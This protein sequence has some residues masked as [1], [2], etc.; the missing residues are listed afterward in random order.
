MPTAK[1]AMRRNAISV[2][3]EATV[4]EAAKL[5][6]NHD[7]DAIAVCENGKFRGLV[8]YQNIVSQ[9]VAD[10]RDAGRERVTLITS[11][12]LP[13][14]CPGIALAEAIKIMAKHRTRVVP[15]VQNGKFVGLLTMDDVMR[16]SPA[17]VVMTAQHWGMPADSRG[18]EGMAIN[19]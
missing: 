2:S 5:M 16:E 12:N 18:S 19:R 11:N 8:T 14:V 4:A 13:K 10:N 15:V 7:M 9:V 17:L 3:P 1:N 6:T